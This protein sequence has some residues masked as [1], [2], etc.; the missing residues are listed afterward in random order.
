MHRLLIAA[1]ALLLLNNVATATEEKV[2][3]K[4]TSCEA[5]DCAHGRCEFT[6]CEAPVSCAGGRCRFVRCKQPSCT[7]GLCDFVECHHPSCSGGAC[8]FLS[9]ETTLKDG[10]CSGGVCHV[11]G[12]VTSSRLKDALAY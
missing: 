3:T 9:T 10:F 5:G 6:D 11:D 12:E 1:L 4:P 2:V 8:H 7:G